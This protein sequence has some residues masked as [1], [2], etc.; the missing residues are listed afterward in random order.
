[1]CI[2]N[3]NGTVE[4][5]FFNVSFHMIVKLLYIIV[6]YCHLVAIAPGIP[7]PFTGAD[8][9]VLGHESGCAS[10]CL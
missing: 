3:V 4:L 7:R 5:E 2:Y 8:V 9:L 6:L 1:M 10:V